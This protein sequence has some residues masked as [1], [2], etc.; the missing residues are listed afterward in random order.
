MGGSGSGKT[1]L[2]NVL[3]GR[4]DKNQ[5]SISGDVRFNGQ[6]PNVFRKRGEVGYLQQED[7][8]LPSV[9]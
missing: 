5:I 4:V 6:H 9:T 2:L 8:L 1:T 3:A 7:T